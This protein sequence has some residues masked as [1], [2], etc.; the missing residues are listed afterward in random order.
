VTVL[1]LVSVFRSQ[2]FFIVTVL[3]FVSLL[4]S[5]LFFIV[6]VLPFVSVLRSQLFFIVTVLP[7][8]S[9]L[10]SQLFF[11]VTVLPF[12]SLLRSQLIYKSAESRPSTLIIFQIRSP[13]TKFCLAAALFLYAARV[14]F[15]IAQLGVVHIY[16]TH[17]FMTVESGAYEVVNTSLAWPMMFSTITKDIF[18]YEWIPLSVI[19]AIAVTI[20]IFNMFADGMQRFF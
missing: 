2:L 14:L 17:K 12:V 3:P 7:L 6:T 18:T 10:R 8:V 20:F 16:V 11:I 4:R 19:G 9:V 15:L 5:Q 13:L 1:P